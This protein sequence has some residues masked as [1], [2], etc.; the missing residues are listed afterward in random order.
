M[1]VTSGSKGIHLYA[2]LDGKQTSDEISAIAHELARA[3]EADHP[4]LV[5]SD[6]KKAVRGGKVLLDWSQNNGSKTTIVPYSLR[7]RLAPDG[8][9]SA[10]LARTA[11]ARAARSSSSP[12]CSNASQEGGPARRT[13]GEPSTWT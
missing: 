6:M 12:R 11:L 1:P 7:G 2:A 10:H 3:L 9:R 13:L 5:V 4:D 8:R